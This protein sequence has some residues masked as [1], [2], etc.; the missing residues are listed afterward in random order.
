MR[1]WRSLEMILLLLSTL[2]EMSLTTALKHWIGTSAACLLLS[3][4]PLLAQTGNVSKFVL[5]SVDRFATVQVQHGV[6]C[7]VATRGCSNVGV[8]G[9]GLQV[10]PPVCQGH[11]PQLSTMT[12]GRGG[13]GRM[14]SASSY[15]MTSSTIWMQIMLVLSWEAFLQQSK[16]RMFRMFSSILLR[17]VEHG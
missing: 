9:V 11:P 12:V 10:V 2:Q 1:W 5:I 6:M 17:R 14:I 15:L 3:I 16:I 8:S 7:C 4:A 13:R